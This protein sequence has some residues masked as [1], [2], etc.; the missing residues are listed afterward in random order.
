MRRARSERISGRSDLPAARLSELSRSDLSGPALSG[1]DLSRANL[2]G[3]ELSRAKLSGAKL[4]GPE[5]SVAS[6]FE[7]AGGGIT[8]LRT[9]G[10]PTRRAQQQR[11]RFDAGR[12]DPTGRTIR[13]A[14]AGESRP[15]AGAGAPRRLRR[16]RILFAVLGTVSA[17]RA[18]QFQDRSNAR[19]S[20]YGDEQSGAAQERR[21]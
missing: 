20:R 21:R 9:S 10:N 18:A 12:P 8:G 17:M 11:Y 13:G 4:S 19:R 15:H 6:G 14:T 5:I 2:S 7:P 3:A 1:A 16:R